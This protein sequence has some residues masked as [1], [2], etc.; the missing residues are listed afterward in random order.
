VKTKYF[1]LPSVCVIGLLELLVAFS[2][3]SLIVI[4][5]NNFVL[6]AV[7]L[8]VGYLLSCLLKKIFGLL[9]LQVKFVIS[10]AN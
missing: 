3:R 7:G 6:Y 9:N 5:C 4:D 8:A 2:S 10:Q 1:I